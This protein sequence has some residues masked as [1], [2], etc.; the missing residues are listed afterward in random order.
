M[1]Q[2]PNYAIKVSL[3]NDDGDETAFE[4]VPTV[5]YEQGA[6]AVARVVSHFEKKQ[7]EAEQ[8]AADQDED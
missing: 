1:S 5:S 3:I 4:I 8:R 2:S 7:A 6:E